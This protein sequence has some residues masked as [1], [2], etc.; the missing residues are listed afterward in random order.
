MKASV[1]RIV[2]Y[3]L[4]ERDAEAINRRRL[5]MERRGIDWPAGAQAHV[6]TQVVAGWTMPMIITGLWSE[7]AVNG[8]VFLDGNDS[9]WVT[10]VSEGSSSGQ[11]SWPPRVE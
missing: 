2:H 11:W 9:L 7:H 5:P 4:S 10:N 6:G 1:G 3:A 8:Q